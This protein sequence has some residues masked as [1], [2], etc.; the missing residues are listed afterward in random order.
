M[1]TEASIAAPPITSP[2]WQDYVMSQFT[3]EELYKGKHPNVN[4]L[5]RVT[6]LVLG[7][8][9]FGKVNTVNIS[10]QETPI[11]SGFRATVE[12]AVGIETEN[13]LLEFSSVADAGPDNA[14]PV[15]RKFP[16]ALA[17]T[18]AESR[19]LRKAL[20]LQVAAAE[21]LSAVAESDKQNE[22]LTKQQ[23]STIKLLS[24]RLGVSLVKLWGIYSCKNDL[25][26]TKHDGI[27]L[28]QSLN[29]WQQDG[30]PEELRS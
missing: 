22:T 18:R 16:A 30:V 3:D 24:H 28:I 19:A 20:K 11:T 27:E 14:D 26:M 15:Y 6:E 17:E 1:E 9:I 2:E 13:G 10:Y 5:R 25:E 4:G 7:P 21:E 29:K 8:I 12:Y 23:L